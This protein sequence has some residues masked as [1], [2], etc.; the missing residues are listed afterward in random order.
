[1]SEKTEKRVYPK[2][3]VYRSMLLLLHNAA[4]YRNADRLIAAYKNSIIRL[5]SQIHNQRR[6]RSPSK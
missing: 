3:A 4:K 2:E 6:G 1:M 5:G